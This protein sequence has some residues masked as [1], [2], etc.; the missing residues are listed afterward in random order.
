MGSRPAYRAVIL[1]GLVSLL[2]DVVYEGGR[3][4]S[5]SYLEKLGSEA[6]LV[7][8]V[9]GLGEF[10]SSGLRLFSGILAD[11]F[12]I[13]W[14][15]YIIGYLAI[16]TIPFIG[17]TNSIFLIAILIYV[18]R[19]AKSLRTPA[20]DTLLSIVSRDIGAGRA[21]GL[22]ELLDQLGATV[23]PGLLIIILYIY[24]DFSLAY[25]FLFIPYLLLILVIVYLYSEIKSITVDISEGVG[26]RALNVRE[27]ITG[28]PTKF[29]LYIL[30]VALNTFGLIHWSL[31]IYKASTLAAGWV[32][33]AL[34]LAMQLTDAFSAPIAGT[35]FDRI[36][37]WTLSLPFLLSVIPT[38][39]TLVGGLDQLIIAVLIFG[40]ILGM[41]ESIYRAA[42]SE[43]VDSRR[44]ATAYGVF[45]AIYGVGL[46]LSGLFYGWLMQS[47]QV[48]I[49]VVTAISSQIA[50]LYILRLTV[51]REQ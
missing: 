48:A 38:V 41:Q 45:N 3:G 28:L 4:I 33:T 7:G 2:A 11:K 5:P 13:Y 22:H 1:F 9:L 43:M 14:L 16:G 10:I 15:L 46:L 21:F 26:Y 34:Y 51:A 20:R 50:A 6:I 32:A 49:G 19:F 31:P 47:G 36:G 39:L 30:A 42:V 44:R 29:K 25:T 35:V 40:V 18:E 23:G 8:G 27:L 37:I 12:R 17:F 24:N